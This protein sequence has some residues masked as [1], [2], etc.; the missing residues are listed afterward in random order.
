M[1]KKFKK[2]SLNWSLSCLWVR[3]CE[4]ISQSKSGVISIMPKS[5]SLIMRI[6]ILQKNHSY[7]TDKCSITVPC[8]PLKHM[9]WMLAKLKA[10]VYSL[11][12]FCDFH[13]INKIFIK[14]IKSP[15]VQAYPNTQAFLIPITTKLVEYVSDNSF[16]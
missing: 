13:R 6:L 14:P 9:I 1:L 5:K 4:I 3:P 12:L 10:L 16:W 11:C 2:S 8:I 15:E 7:Y